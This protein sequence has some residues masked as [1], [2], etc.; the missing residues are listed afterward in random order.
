MNFCNS[1][2]QD[3]HRP[4]KMKVHSR[5]A[6]FPEDITEIL[7]KCEKEGKL[8]D[9][10]SLKP[11]GKSVHKYVL[12]YEDGYFYMWKNLS[13]DLHL[14]T[15]LTLKLNN[16][17][18]L[19][20]N[21]TEKLKVSLPPGTVQY[22]HFQRINKNEACSCDISQRFAL[23]PAKPGKL[24]SVSIPVVLTKDSSEVELR[25]WTEKEGN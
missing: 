15:E 19:D 9:F 18:I 10:G 25:K 11:E 13:K 23:T 1:C 6:R 16:L 14:D 22:I 12:E 20:H 24:P 3:L 17:K 8:S 4:A 2:D 5:K 21:Q 7:I